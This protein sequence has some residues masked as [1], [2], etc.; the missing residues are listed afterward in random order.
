VRGSRPAPMAKKAPRQ[1]GF[2]LRMAGEND[3][4]ADG[5]PVSSSAGQPVGRDTNWT[6]P[7]AIRA[8]CLILLAR[9]T[10]I[11]PVFSP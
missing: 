5:H 9:P 1:C 8:K 10:G 2:N 7:P 11:E 6:P 3:E 4:M